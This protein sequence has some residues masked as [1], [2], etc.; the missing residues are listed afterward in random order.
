MG[1]RQ[2]LYTIK[3][4]VVGLSFPTSALHLEAIFLKDID[5]NVA[6]A[7]GSLLSSRLVTQ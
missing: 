3:R 7:Y 4:A 5:G 1:L 6:T 2:K